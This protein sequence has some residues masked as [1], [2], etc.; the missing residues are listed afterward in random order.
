MNDFKNPNYWN[1]KYE[2][3]NVVYQ[4]RVMRN[5]TKPITVDVRVFITRKDELLQRIIKFFRLKR[6]NFNE[7]VLKCHRFV[8]N[9]LIF[10]EDDES[11]DCPEFWQF[12]FETIHTGVGD[13]EDG[14]IL[15][16]SLMINAGI[17]TWRV[18]VASGF[19]LNIKNK[20]LM[21]H[22]YVLYL[23]DRPESKRG[24]EWVVLDWC[25]LKDI[26][27]KIE[28]KPLAKQGGKL[29]AYR[30]IWFTFNDE[31]CWSSNSFKI[32]EGR[33][34]NFDSD[35]DQNEREKRLDKIYDSLIKYPKKLKKYFFNKEN[36]A[37]ILGDPNELVEKI[38]EIIEK[39]GIDLDDVDLD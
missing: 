38:N 8:A 26:R 5:K 17:P 32:K 14:A 15:L 21:G 28:E 16:A 23:A 35:L 4:G 36:L 1:N 29:N 7:T 37:L 6:D 11:V 31:Y 22:T 9:F 27:L 2:L 19:V 25:Y 39:E 30:Q 10:K 13:C 18:K 12:P 34:R 3:S 20:K 24:L 33:D